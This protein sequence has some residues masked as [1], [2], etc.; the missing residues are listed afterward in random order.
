MRSKLEQIWSPARSSNDV[1]TLFC[2]M[3]VVGVAGVHKALA[4]IQCY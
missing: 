3:P 2:S 4:S 1:H